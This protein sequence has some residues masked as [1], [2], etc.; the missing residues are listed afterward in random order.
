MPIGVCIGI[1]T[2]IILIL[3]TQLSSGA[4]KIPLFLIP[5]TFTLLDLSCVSRLF[6]NNLQSR[7]CIWLILACDGRFGLWFRQ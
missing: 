6:L 3:L 4:Q 1:Y 5:L 7:G 2:P